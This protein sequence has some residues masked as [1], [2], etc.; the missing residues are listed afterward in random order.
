MAPSAFVTAVLTL[1]ATGVSGLKIEPPTALFPGAT[2]GQ[3]FISIPVSAPQK[4]SILR[5]RADV[6]QTTHVEV[7]NFRSSNYVIDI[8]IGTPPQ[9]LTVAVDT[10]SY[11]LWVNPDCSKSSVARNV[12]MDGR[13]VQF[14]DTPLSDPAECR[15]RGNYDPLISS[16]AGAADL[17][18]EKFSYA[19]G[20]TV[21]VGYLKD[22]ISVGGLT[23]NDQI[24]G[25]AQA[26]NQTGVGIMG[27][28]PP[29]WGFNNSGM[30]PMIL[31][32]MARQGVINSPAFSMHLGDLDNST[33]TITF[34]GVDKK[35]YKG[36]LAKI[37]FRTQQF[38]TSDGQPFD[39]TS[40]YV[41][42][43]SIRLTNPG[44]TDSKSYDLGSGDTVASLDC[45]STN[46]ILPKGLTKSVCDDL[47]GTLRNNGKTCDVD[48]AIRRQ[49]GGMTFGLEG[50][51][52]LV[53]FYN[54]IEER[55]NR[56]VASCHVMMNDNDLGLD[57][58]THILGAPFLRSSYAVFDWGNGNLHIAQAD[59]CGTNIVAIGN[60]TDAVPGG[61]GECSFGVKSVVNY[62]LMFGAALFAGLSAL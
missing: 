17:D 39:H 4:D 50:K 46:N 26:S 49:P 35:K 13:T 51:D 15:K 25:V 18:D 10:G 5:K 22:R 45:G 28:G 61:N 56:E 59:N 21:E 36:S 40:Y 43:K 14:V 30:Y 2:I 47:K 31:T 29:P 9:K 3:G 52:I 16:T 42:I 32:S 23:I 11:K 6:D 55:V 44:T 20:T 62:G 24:F 33:G 38:K 8:S 1:A 37:P 48:C 41:N 19:D 58:E 7:A 12:T 27:F 53:P 57:P 60:G 54:L 34:G